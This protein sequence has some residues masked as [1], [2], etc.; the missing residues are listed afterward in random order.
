VSPRNIA[1]SGIG[2]GSASAYNGHKNIPSGGLVIV[3]QIAGGEVIAMEF[4]CS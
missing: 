3:H 4:S 1:G 2:T